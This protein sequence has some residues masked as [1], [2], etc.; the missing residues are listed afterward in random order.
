[1]LTAQQGFGSTVSASLGLSGQFSRDTW[2]LV[3]AGTGFTNYTVLTSGSLKAYYANS[4]WSLK[5][6]GQGYRAGSVVQMTS[7]SGYDAYFYKGS[8]VIA[9]GYMQNNIFEVENLSYPEYDINDNIDKILD[10]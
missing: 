9:S 1:M 4:N 7:P 8:I 5:T 10:E 3:S 6:G 2:V